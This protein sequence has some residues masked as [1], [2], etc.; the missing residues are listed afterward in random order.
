[1][2][3][4][5]RPGSDV[6]SYDF[7]FRGR[8][9]SG[10]TGCTTERGAK[11]AEKA[12]RARA[13]VNEVDT[14]KPL[15]MADAVF[16]YWNEVGQHH[17]DPKATLRILDWLQSA[18]GKKT[19]VSEITDATVARLV[20]Q[21]RA[22]GVKPATVNRSM[23]EPLRGLM[24]RAG[25]V[26]GVKVARIEWKKHRLKEPQ[27]RVREASA[28]EEA[29]ALAKVPADYAPAVRFALMTGCRRAEIVGLTWQDVNFF[30]KELRVTGKGDRS[31]TIPMTREAFDLLWAL[32]DHHP[33][34]VFT[35]LATRTRDGRVRGTRYPITIP[36]F[37]TAWNRHVRPHLSDFRF[38][39]TRHT[40]ATRLMRATGKMKSVQMMLGHEDIAT[41]S[42]YAHVTLD[43]L[44]KDME[45]AAATSG[46]TQSATTPP[47]AS[48]KDLKDIG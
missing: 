8:R 37:Q 43:D 11:Q 32:K 42:R 28:E 25:D 1:M 12:E 2:S 45:S 21:R 41:T 40:A 18:I 29:I 20:A 31:R 39:D 44:R 3:V 10:S 5:K 27:E 38:H 23:V 4:F 7:R 9:F 19:L 36:G 46:I 6:F 47:K 35:F 26:W 13:R 22:E 15:T 30:A 24:R 17:R 33:T 14:T 48:A 34:A 16:L